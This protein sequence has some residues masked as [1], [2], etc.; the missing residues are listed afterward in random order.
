MS[1]SR[2]T[3]I[4]FFFKKLNHWEA[5]HLVEGSPAGVACDPGETGVEGISSIIYASTDHQTNRKEGEAVV[6]PRSR[7]IRDGAGV[8]RRSREYFDAGEDSV[9]AIRAA[10]Q[11]LP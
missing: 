4:V 8:R 6:Y 7:Q 5:P 3:V 11:D 9:F 10:H 1:I 2:H